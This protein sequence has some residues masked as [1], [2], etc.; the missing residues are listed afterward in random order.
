MSRPAITNVTQS[1]NTS[2]NKSS[3]TSAFTHPLGHTFTVYADYTVW[4]ET[5]NKAILFQDLTRL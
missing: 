3:A 5:N 1:T 2:T 4:D